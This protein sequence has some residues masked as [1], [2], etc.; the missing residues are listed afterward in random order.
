MNI[1]IICIE[2]IAESILFLSTFCIASSLQNLKTTP[3]RKL[4]FI[5]LLLIGIFSAIFYSNCF[6]QN[7]AIQLSFLILNYAKFCIGNIIA[8]KKCH[9]KVIIMILTTQAACDLLN[10]SLFLFVPED[11]NVETSLINAIIFLIVRIAVL[12]VLLV[13]LKPGNNSFKSN[14]IEAI[15][16]YIF[17]LALINFIISSGLVRVTGFDTENF[18]LKNFLIKILA[19]ANTLCLIVVLVSLLTNVLFRQYQKDINKILENQVQIQLKHYEKSEK[20][21]TEI[22]R[23]RHDYNN[24]MNCMKSL[25][26]SGRYDE[27]MDYINNISDAFPQSGFLYNTG[28]YIADAILTDK[29]ENARKNGTNISFKGIISPSINNTD[30]CIILGNILDNAVEA[31]EKIDGEKEISVFGGYQHGYFILI[32]KNPISCHVQTENGIPATTKPDTAYHGFGLQNV[33]SVVKKYD[34]I[35]LS[36]CSDDSFTIRLTFNSIQETATV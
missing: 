32:A 24:H 2:V 21:N 3:S 36:E 11:D 20:I 28:N 30:L 31:C 1:L 6:S 14:A 27:L 16:S 17:V 13:F 7:I 35:M 9:F 33:E 23:F 10:A 12:I 18:Q 34:G 5:I 4:I 22:R 29:L 19:F 15:P 26:Q 25:V 8:C